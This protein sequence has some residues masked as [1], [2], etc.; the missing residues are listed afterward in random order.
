MFDALRAAEPDKIFGLM[1]IYR[2]DP[3]PEKI[4]LG[5]G[6]YRDP[7]GATPVFKAIHE[8]ERRLWTNE[9][10]KTYVGLE[11]DPS[12]S[13]ALTELVLGP[14]A[15]G[16]RARACQTSGGAGALRILGDLLARAKS[17]ATVWISNPTWPNHVALVRAARLK[18]AEYPYYNIKQGCVTF[19]A[20]L[21]A[22]SDAGKGDIVLLHGCCHNPTGADLSVE[23]WKTLTQLLISRGLIA[24][25]DLAYQGFGRGME[26]DVAG[27]RHL[28]VTAPESAIAVS[29]SKNFGVYR[30]RVGCAIVVGVDPSQAEIAHSQMVN[31]VRAA[32]SM[33]PNW[34][35]AAV[36]AVLEMPDLRTMWRDELDGM[37][38]RMND[39]RSGLSQALKSRTNS[40]KYDFLEH[41]NGM[42]SLL[43]VTSDQVRELREK[44]AIYMIDDGRINVAGLTH[45]KI[46]KVADAIIGVC[47]S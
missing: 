45:E 8:A 23:Q 46:A 37:R 31:V 3:R 22:L 21:E 7:T 12:F 32:H 25:V 15:L 38:T 19:E 26:D 4:D 16:G 35:A 9:T 27:L 41:Q 6:V 36:R 29:C 5:I 20:M 47:G 39:L 14:G 1:Q 2:D 28:V 30:D 42:F 44:R 43:P 40:D 17:D 34:G 33:A 13:K 10:S 18:I 24:F 11:G